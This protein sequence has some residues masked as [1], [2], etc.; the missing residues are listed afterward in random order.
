MNFAFTP[1]EAWSVASTV[2]AHLK[3]QGMKVKCEVEPFSGS[4]Y[5]PTLV[6]TKSGLTVIV[7]AQGNLDYHATIAFFATWLAAKRHYAQ[8]YLSTTED[9]VTHAV[10]LAEMRKAGVGWW[11]VHENK[12]ISESVS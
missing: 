1:E 9:C 3:R 12:T 2:A 10:T 7:E 5:R 4:P 6:A 8:L 11:V